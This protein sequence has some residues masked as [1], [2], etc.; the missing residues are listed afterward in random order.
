MKTVEARVRN[1]CRRHGCEIDTSPPCSRNPYNPQI[2]II[3]PDDQT[4]LYGETSL[5]CF[6]W[7]DA[8]DRLLA[9]Y[10]V[11]KAMNHILSKE[12]V[13][14]KIQKDVQNKVDG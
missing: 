10:F 2:E 9:E 5:L 1:W 6:T 12:D 8:W 11:E 7:H 14:K 4:F 3:L 13:L